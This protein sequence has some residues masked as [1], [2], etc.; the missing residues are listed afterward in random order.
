MTSYVYLTMTANIVDSLDNLCPGL[1]PNDIDSAL[2]GYVDSI[3]S[4]YDSWIA[5]MYSNIMLPAIYPA[6]QFICRP[7]PEHWQ[8]LLW[9]CSDMEISS[10]PY[11][12]L[13]A[14]D[15]DV[16]GSVVTTAPEVIITMESSTASTTSSSS[17]TSITTATM[18]TTPVRTTS[19]NSCSFSSTL[20]TSISSPSSSSS[21][22][23]SVSSSS[24]LHANST[25]PTN[26]PLTSSQ[27]A[28]SSAITTSASP[29]ASHASHFCCPLHCE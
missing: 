19:I 4:I 22:S 24:V 7:F 29:S 11:L 2:G 28:S 15:Y 21:S 26:A 18:T 13:A 27:A 20:M 3:S 8:H 1:N 16:S 9:I 23:S 17:S 14:A 12:A 6:G 5:T 10:C 25:R